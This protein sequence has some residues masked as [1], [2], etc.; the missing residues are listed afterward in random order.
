MKKLFTA[1]LAAA[2]ISPMSLYA[3]EPSHLYI[4][5]AWGNYSLDIKNY[6]ASYDSSSGLAL[7]IGYD[8][9][10][11]FAIQGSY[12]APDTFQASS[13][14]DENISYA[15]SLFARANLRFQRWTLFGL[16]GGTSVSGNNAEYVNTINPAYG[17]GIDFYGTKDVAITLKYVNY[18]DAKLKVIGNDVSLSGTTIGFTYYFDT[19]R[20]SKRY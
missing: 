10:N 9:T 7:D 4:G 8:F 2:L 12:I 3:A 15:T 18:V 14:N 5:A 16:A 17:V 6:S 1:L 20:F 13:G 11:V 19:P